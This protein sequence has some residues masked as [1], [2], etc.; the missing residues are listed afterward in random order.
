MDNRLLTIDGPLYHS[1]AKPADIHRNF[2]S[3]WMAV[4]HAV[5]PILVVDDSKTMTAIVSRILKDA[6]Y[7][8]IDRVH[9][10]VSALEKLRQKEYDLVITDWQMQPIS[11]P[12]LIKRIR[13]DARLSKVRTILITAL[14]DKDDE[15]WLDGADGYVTKPFEPRDLV[16]KVEDVLATIA[17]TAVPV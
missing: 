1:L 11:G 9:D 10:G 3:A 4:M 7:A 8:D 15:A 12:E 17:P 14:H 2:H 5:K 13:A 16:T 6:N